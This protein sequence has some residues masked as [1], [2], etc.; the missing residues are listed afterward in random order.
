MAEQPRVLG[1]Y[2][3]MIT[4]K[5]GMGFSGKTQDQKTYWFVKRIDDDRYEVQPLNSQHV[6]SGLCSVISKKEF[7]TEYFPELDY[8]ERKT[9]PALKSLQNKLAKGEDCFA[10]EQLGDAEKEFTKALFIDE[11]NPQASIRLGEVHCL[12]KEYEKLKIA[13]DR[14]LNNDAVFSEQE[15]HRFNE[16]G[17]SLR[18]NGYHKES[19]RYYTKALEVNDSDEHLHFNIARVYFDMEDVGQC[20]NH[21]NAALKIRPKFKEASDF[22]RYCEVYSP[23]D[24]NLEPF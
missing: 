13:M 7:I 3:K 17:I 8:Y 9:V 16:F 12:K 1:V 5:T 11:K 18:K 10:K 24:L 4:L 23:S 2:S 21:L 14:I 20:I 15:R 19:L 22:L 6:P